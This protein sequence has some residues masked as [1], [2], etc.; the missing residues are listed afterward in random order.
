MAKR[1]DTGS[2]KEMHFGTYRSAIHA[3][4][5]NGNVV[6]EVAPDAP[7]DVDEL[8]QEDEEE[9]RHHENREELLQEH[10][11]EQPHRRAPP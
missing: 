8:Q 3:T 9:Q 5:R 4:C 2:A 11:P 10:P 7:E 6:R 1:N